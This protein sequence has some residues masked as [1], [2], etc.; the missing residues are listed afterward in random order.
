MVESIPPPMTFPRLFLASR[1]WPRLQTPPLS[2]GMQPVSQRRAALECNLLEFVRRAVPDCLYPI[3][4]SLFAVIF[5]GPIHSDTPTA[6][7]EKRDPLYFW[8]VATITT[9][10]HR[11]RYSCILPSRV[12]QSTPFSH[13][14]QRIAGPPVP[15][16]LHPSQNV[17]PPTAAKT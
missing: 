2:P 17:R 14:R 4:P 11:H 7:D 8:V 15:E 6:N 12:I 9:L 10:Y 16:D 3:P 1:S 13:S 5:G